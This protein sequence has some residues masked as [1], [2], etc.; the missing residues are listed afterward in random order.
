MPAP[1]EPAARHFLEGEGETAAR[2]RAL[3]WSSTPLG[4]P[5]QWPQSLKTVASVCL[6][7][8]F[9]MLIW[10]GP[11]L[12]MLYNDAYRPIL[13]QK[14]PRALGQQG[15]ECWP[16]IWDLIGPMLRGVLAGAAATWAADQL[17]MLER[18]GYPEECFFT[19]SYSP[20]FDESG[21]VGGVFTAVTETTES[22]V[23]QR[24]L[25]TLNRLTDALAEL[26]DPER[27]VR[28]GV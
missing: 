16:E 18:N 5:A 24:R 7:S 1:I 17:L 3:D 11:D 10:W 8:R 25:G 26:R 19:F 28:T 15:E 9:P 22:V 6:H 20:I 13:G 27:I 12:V 4:P 2:M 23:N 14:H 21:G